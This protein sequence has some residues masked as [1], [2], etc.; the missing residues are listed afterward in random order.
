MACRAQ[1][2]SRLSCLPMRA[3]S[4]VASPP[5]PTPR[6]RAAYLPRFAFVTALG[7]CSFL[8]CV[9]YEYDAVAG[10][11]LESSTDMLLVPD[12]RP[13]TPTKPQLHSN[14]CHDS[15]NGT[16]TKPIATWVRGLAFREVSPGN[17]KCL[18]EVDRM[19]VLCKKR[20]F[21]LAYCYALPLKR[22][23]NRKRLSQGPEGTGSLSGFT[24]SLSLNV[25]V[26]FFCFT[27]H[28]LINSHS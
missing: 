3:R 4:S 25:V 15:Y 16:R 22:K 19:L 9:S 11:G 1:P 20:V 13:P 10:P 12:Q 27:N 24:I 18:F 14:K 28:A 2:T 7:L 5:V 17:L 8:S 6:S 21:L 26:K 23:I